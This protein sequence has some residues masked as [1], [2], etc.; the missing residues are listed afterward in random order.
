MSAKLNGSKYSAFSVFIITNLICY[1]RQNFTIFR[2][3]YHRSPNYD[4]ALHSGAFIY[5]DDSYYKG[6]CRDLFQ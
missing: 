2:R 6:K 4:F 5:T 1:C 3:I